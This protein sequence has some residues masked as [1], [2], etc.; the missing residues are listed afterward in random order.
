MSFLE[1]SEFETI[2]N[3][4]RFKRNVSYFDPTKGWVINPNRYIRKEAA[5]PK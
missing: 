5:S 4:P 3:E 2:S 1:Y